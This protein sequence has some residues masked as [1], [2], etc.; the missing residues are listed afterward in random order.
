VN[1]DHLIMVTITV[2]CYLRVPSTSDHLFSCGTIFR[3]PD[4]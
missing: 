2:T 3:P 4:W 1:Y